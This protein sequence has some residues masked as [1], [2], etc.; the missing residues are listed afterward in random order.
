MDTLHIDGAYGEG[1]GQ[2]LRTS[3]TLSALTGRPFEL[4]N[5]RA[6]RPRPG[7][8]PQHLTAVRAVASICGADVQ[9][10]EIDSQMLL[11]RPSVRPAGGSYRI[12][13]RDA[14]MG[15][16][17]GAITLIAQTLYLPLSF[18]SEPSGVTLCGGTHVPWSPPFH[19]FSEVFQPAMA[20]LGLG[21]S[22]ELITWGWYP[23]GGGEILLEIQP[24]NRLRNLVWTERGDLERVTG[25]AAVTNLPSHIPQRMSSRC[26]SIL[27]TAGINCQ[28]T[29][30]RERG[31]GA[32][33]GIFIT[34]EYTHG[35]LGFSSIGK[36]GK[37][38]ELVA[39]EACEE[40]FKHH[41]AA[42]A[43]AVDAHLADQLILPM[44]LASGESIISTSLISNHTKTNSYVIK[45]F[46]E[47]SIEIEQR[48][49]GG[50]IFV[51]GIDY[52]V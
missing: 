45:Q 52:H 17:A 48:G 51:K 49:D 50:I 29:P 11:F 28:I 43:P 6:N 35:S 5:I 30:L 42:L 10:D 7:L 14:A 37:A 1:G 12:D 19:H 34:A 18:A 20:R 40:L 22:T 31:P 13:V 38:S 15:G 33:A 8:R 24:V 36:K 32:G 27:R 9:G 23:E 3:L 16:S 4:D 25:V 41:N 26:S 21:I 2:V 47:N 39:E 44:A 46:L